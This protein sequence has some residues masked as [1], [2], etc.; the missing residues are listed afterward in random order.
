[1]QAVPATAA[2]R[3]AWLRLAAEVEYLF[4]PLVGDPGF[5][6]ALSRNIDRGSALCVRTSEGLAGGLLLSAHHPLYRIGWLAVSQQH[7]KQG[8]GALL[9]RTAIGTLT[10]APGAVEV[11]TFG[12]EHQGKDAS[13]F[14]ERLGFQATG[15]VSDD[16]MRE[17]YG[18]RLT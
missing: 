15:W 9:V 4:G 2:D 1:M 14:Y 8:V 5:E 7:R 6:A 11:T 18:L 10:R 12:P 3:P 17:S 13:G 16:G